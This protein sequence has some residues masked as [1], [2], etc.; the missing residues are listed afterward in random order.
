MKKV[1]NL[2]L[3]AGISGLA[4]AQ[5]LY[6]KNQ[7]F[8]IVEQND[9][10][11]G[12]C[13]SYNIDGFIFDYFVHFSFTANELV[14]GYFDVVPYNS[15]VP[16]PYNY[17]HG[18]WIKHP[19][20]N[21]LFPL[22]EREKAEILKGIKNRNKYSDVWSDNYENWLRYQFGDYFA[23]HFSLA[24][25]RKYWAEDAKNMETSWIG[26]RIYQPSLDEIRYGMENSDTP[27]TFYAKEMRYP[28][29]GGFNNFLK[30]IIHSESIC[31]GEK[32]AKI[33]IINKIVYTNN[34]VYEYNNLFSSIPLPE[35][36]N[37]CDSVNSDESLRQAIMD[38]HWTGGYI[39]SLGFKGI[40]PRE[41]LWDYVYDDD[42]FVSRYYSPSSMSCQSVPDG[43]YSLQAEIYTKDGTDSYDEDDLLN[44]VIN[45][46]DRMGVVRK[47][48]LVV[49][50]IRF[51]KYC[52][53]VFDHKIYQNRNLIINY[54]SSNSVIPI[55]RF[56]E[57]EYY[58]SDQS[59]ISGYLAAKNLL[60]CD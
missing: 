55:G 2:I 51:V 48:E 11:G 26:N 31:L 3:G 41:D 30:P 10:I 25:T 8:V 16:N 23:E 49:K 34:E 15:H 38:L 52:N 18:L 44:S 9:Y 22:D 37:I 27:V 12:L 50:D 17:Y 43:C 33:D 20:Q 6:E 13:A 60:N 14:R 28:I 32:V 19:A 57:W 4:A 47:S 40:N 29:S 36:L 39:V 35:L 59:F 42:I 1:N 56:G 46:L 54:L 5:C 45:Q 7:E 24:Y 58:W 21:N 53:I